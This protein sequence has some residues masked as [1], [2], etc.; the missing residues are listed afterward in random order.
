M[1]DQVRFCTTKDAVGWFLVS[2]YV[3]I[4]ILDVLVHLIRN[5]L[6]LQK[7]TM[8]ACPSCQLGKAGGYHKTGE[9]LFVDYHKCQSGIARKHGPGKLQTDCPSLSLPSPTPSPPSLS[10][11]I[12]YTYRSLITCSEQDGQREKGRGCDA[13]TPTLQ[14]ATSPDNSICIHSSLVSR[15]PSFSEKMIILG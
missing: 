10:P 12:I 1:I 7:V 6:P 14:L 15:W 4:Y 2:L 8:Q 5:E 3:W 9:Q 13:T 11:T